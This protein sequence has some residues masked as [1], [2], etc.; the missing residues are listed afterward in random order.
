MGLDRLGTKEAKKMAYNWCARYIRSN[1]LG[2]K[3]E[4]HCNMYE[5]V[6][7]VFLSIDPALLNNTLILSTQQ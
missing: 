4:G 1:Y 2:Y 5:K 6:C 7:F 3:R